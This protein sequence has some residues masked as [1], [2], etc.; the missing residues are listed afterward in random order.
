MAA[1][2][3]TCPVSTCPVL[4]DAGVLMCNP[5]WRRVPVALR[6]ALLI[7]WKAKDRKRWRD[8]MRGAIAAVEAALE[9]DELAAASVGRWE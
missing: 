1:R 5:H 9:R 8:A 2:G 7:A 6:W 3:H 4:L